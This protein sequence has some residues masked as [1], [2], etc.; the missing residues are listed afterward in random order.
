MNSMMLC[1]HRN[2]NKTNNL[3]A[4]AFPHTEIHKKIILHHDIKTHQL[5]KG[6]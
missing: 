2:M 1:T 4:L 5:R 6:I 3:Y